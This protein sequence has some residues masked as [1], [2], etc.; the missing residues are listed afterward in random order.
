MKLLRSLS[1][2]VS[3]LAAG[4]MTA[5]VTA[6]EAETRAYFQKVRH[7]PALLRSFLYA[8]P[9]GGELHNHLDGAIYA[10]SYIRWA[11]EDGK[12]I[13]LESFMITT[14]PCGA[15]AVR[16]AVSGIRYDGDMVN[17]IIDAFSIRNY[18]RRG[19][20]GHDQFFS[21]FRRFIPAGVG[22][23]G[24][25][26]AESSARSARQNILYLEL[27]QSWGM[28]QARQLAAANEEFSADTL[29]AELIRHPDIENLVAA[30][31]L[32]LDGI[33]Q[34]WRSALACGQEHA[35]PGCAVTVRYLAQVIRVFPR[36]QVLA[37]TL[38]AFHLI[39]KD[40]RYVGLNF[41][42]PE[43]N[44]VT[45]RDYR[46]QMEMIG[47]LAG[48][49]PTAKDGITLHAGEVSMGLVPPEHLGW[50]IRAALEIAGA[51][52]I[53]HGTDIFYDPQATQ[54]MEQMAGQGILVEINLTSSEAILGITGE[55]HPIQAYRKYKVPIAL[56]TDDEGVARIDLTHE[57]QRA[58]ETYDLDYDD[59]KYL[60]RNA[61]AYSFLPGESLLESTYTGKMV[62]QCDY[63]SAGA[64]DECLPSAAT[65]GDDPAQQC[66]D[67]EERL[68]AIM[69][70][71]LEFKF[72]NEKAGLQS[73]LERRF[74]EFEASYGNESA[75]EE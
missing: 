43:D 12:C 36:A 71:C 1:L 46:W 5:G 47:E 18:E 74:K 30:T 4:M 54:L 8:F 72:G 25:M 44:P 24:D 3:V 11:A 68:E 15:Y 7:E 55:K 48:H 40:P 32:K 2:A 69:E 75:D 63:N 23:E 60:S 62:K 21:T 59:L 37:Q 29:P 50:H 35:D 28:E 41:V 67:E 70:T 52:R 22:H 64:A 31:I 49:F 56:S 42:A 57:Y 45:L 39:E 73:E 19:I 16:P 61:L 65:E 66:M 53:G 51:R 26:L 27:L 10:E 20:S 38:L 58:V 13:D 34:Q 9:K 17:R 6:G 14:P 33:E